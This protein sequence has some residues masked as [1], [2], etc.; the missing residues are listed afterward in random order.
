MAEQ[1]KYHIAGGMTRGQL[2]AM[3]EKVIKTLEEIGMDA[4]NGNIIEF[5][6]NIPGFNV[7]GQNIRF[8]RGLITECMQK[9]M[10][11]RVNNPRVAPENRPWMLRI[12]TGYPFFLADYKTLT[13]K[14]FLES[15]VIR[16]TKLVDALHPRGV[17]GSTPGAPQDVNPKIRDI[18]T[19]QI[20]AKYCR[21]GGEIGNISG[22]DVAKWLYRLT[23]LT[24]QPK[25][26]GLFAGNPLKAEGATFDTLYEFRK[27]IKAVMV[28]CMPQMG[29]S[30]PVS[31]LGTYVI[32]L[33]AVWGSYAIANALTGIEDMGFFCYPWPTHMKTMDIAYGTPEAAF[34]ELINRQLI[35]YYGWSDSDSNCF[36]SSAPVPDIQAG[37]QRGAFGMMAALRGD[38][39]YRFGGLL[40][41]DLVF[42]P[43]ML[44]G[45]LDAMEYIKRVSEGIYFDD[46]A[47]MM[48][49]IKETGASGTFLDHETTLDYKAH[50][51]DPRLF[52]HE[53][54]PTWISNGSKTMLDK[55]HHEIEGLIQSFDYRLNEDTER[56]LDKICMLA[57]K[58]LL[59]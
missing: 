56:E 53:S 59:G 11:A 49:A 52:V 51:W 31:I 35:E 36:H 26:L 38:R 28:A 8:S 7:C 14:P 3:N 2:D 37:Y 4:G 58:D 15:D 33:A 29:V 1:I 25:G 47:F 30:S 20:G 13:I 21:S 24:G 23:D 27:E 17:T 22:P 57:E 18:R 40:G 50:L 44:L 10:A 6:R 42:S 39:F 19:Y 54:A 12:L 41:T 43:E 5:V 9:Q 45:D 48:N 16:Y 46:D 55:A 32:A 34:S